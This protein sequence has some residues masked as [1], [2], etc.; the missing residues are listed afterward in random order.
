MHNTVRG[1][2]VDLHPVGIKE[3]TNKVVEGKREAPGHKLRK[4]NA[5]VG[6]WFG[7]YLLGRR[8]ADG[9]LLRGWQISLLAELEQMGVLDGGPRPIPAVLL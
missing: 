7:A 9:E 8:S 1:E 6:A 4:A 5:L 3:A 2:I